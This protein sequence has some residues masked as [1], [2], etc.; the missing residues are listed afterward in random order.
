MDSINQKAAEAALMEQGE[1]D[2]AATEEYEVDEEP[3]ANSQPQ[4]ICEHDTNIKCMITYLHV[5]FFLS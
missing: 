5:F 4:G 1:Q 2:K 3:E